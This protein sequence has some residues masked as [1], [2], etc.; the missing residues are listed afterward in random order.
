MNVKGN[1]GSLF[2]DKILAFS[3][4]NDALIS[5]WRVY[6]INRLYQYSGG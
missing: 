3:S 1:G 4:M 6:V 5:N 2:Q